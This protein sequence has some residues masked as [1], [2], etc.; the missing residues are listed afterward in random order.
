MSEFTIGVLS[1]AAF[2]GQER[3]INKASGLCTPGYGA[4]PIGRYYIFD[5]RSGGFLGP[6][7]ERLNLNGNN[8]SEWFALHAIDGDIDD[9]KLLCDGIVRGRFRL[10]P[11]GRVGKSE[12]CITIDQLADWHRIRSIL[13]DEPKV[14]VPGSALKAYGEVMVV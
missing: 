13:T 4:I 6:W 8:K 11:K 5:R 12:G 1:F 3:Y 14:S 2:S 9:D 7:K 10:H